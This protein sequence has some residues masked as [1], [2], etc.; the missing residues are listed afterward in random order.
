MRRVLPAPIFCHRSENMNSGNFEYKNHSAGVSQYHL[1]WC[2]KYRYNALRSV[3]VKE[4]LRAN[5]AETAERYGMHMHESSIEDDHVH[6]FI[7]IPIKLSVS[8]AVMLLKGVSSHELFRRFEGFRLRYKK[9]HFWSR[10]FFFRSVS[11]VT[12]GAI[13][14]YIKNQLH[15]A[16]RAGQ[17]RL[18]FN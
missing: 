9:G 10:G 7:A 16:V 13:D 2:P 18:R 8:R 6:I 15:H 14:H 1:E 3:H 12:S 11:N 5:F 17:M 4:F